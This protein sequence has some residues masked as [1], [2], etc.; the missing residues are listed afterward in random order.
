MTAVSGAGAVVRSVVL[1]KMSPQE[2]R[3]ALNFEAEKYIPFKPEET[4][5]DFS[6]VGDRPGG[7][8]EIL[9]AAAKRDLVNTHL[10]LLKAAQVNPKAV[11]L[12]MLALNNC[13]EVSHPSGGTETVAL[14]HVGARATILVLLEGL[15]FRFGRE[16]G[17]GGEIFTRAIAEG[18]KLDVSE[19]ERIKCHPENRLPEVQAALAPRWEEWLSQC[20]ISF[21]FYEDH[22]GRG[23][24]RLMLSGG[25][26]SL[27]GFRD[28]IQSASA[29]PTELWDPL[30][31]ITLGVAPE[32]IEP[33]R[34]M[35]GVAVGLA[36]RELAAGSD[37]RRGAM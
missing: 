14:V 5:L 29:I 3:G 26:A 1:P 12:E 32:R 2:L 33:V 30:A 10:E 36:V 6:I 19:A 35:L 18:L 31:G 37:S 13:W 21:D 34:G 24:Q 17:I 20:R 15:Q 22:F 11:D 7:R 25:S 28:W 4:F 23:V 9:L 27:K 8:M 16:I